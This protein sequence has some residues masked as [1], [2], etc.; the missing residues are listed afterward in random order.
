MTAVDE[1]IRPALSDFMYHMERELRMN[2]DRGGWKQ[3]DPRDLYM[4]AMKHIGRLGPLLSYQWTSNPD[5]I[6]K[7]AASAANFL[8]M[9][10]DKAKDQY[11]A[12]R[13]QS[14]V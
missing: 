1:Y 2:E 9:I 14:R 12:S 6:A 5:E 4:K 10:H 13:V 7:A 3:D 11:D 8:M